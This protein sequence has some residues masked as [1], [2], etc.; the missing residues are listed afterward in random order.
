MQCFQQVP[1]H[2]LENVHGE[3]VS[4]REEKQGLDLFREQQKI[5]NKR[6]K[7]FHGN[8]EINILPLMAEDWT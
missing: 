7:Q 1:T 4:D 3:V 6:G 2:A 8:Q 5:E